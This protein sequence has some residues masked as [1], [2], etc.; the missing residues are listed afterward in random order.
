[1]LSTTP[2]RSIGTVLNTVIVSDRGSSVGT[3]SRRVSLNLVLEKINVEWKIVHQVI[4][5]LRE[6]RN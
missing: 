4:T 6:R 1:M 2:H 5:D 3:G